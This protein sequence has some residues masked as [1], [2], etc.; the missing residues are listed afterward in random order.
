MNIIISVIL[1]LV[2]A[3]FSAFGQI[4]FKL[5]SKKI[6]LKNIFKNKFLFV[7]LSLYGFGTI[8]F[9]VSLKGG[10]LTVLYPLVS[11]S[12]IWTIFLA[13]YYLKE[14]ITINKLFG[15]LLTMIGLLFIF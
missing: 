14:K 3:I 6:K 1:V 2:S 4:A 5:S 8:L 13:N 10:E 7:G 9:I 15:I 12:Y 11:T